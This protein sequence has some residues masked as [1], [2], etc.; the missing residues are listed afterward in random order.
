MT[1][2]ASRDRTDRDDTAEDA[3]SSE[4]RR[5]E[6]GIA[7]TRANMTTTIAAL[8]AKLNPTE[9]RAKVG[10]ELEH[11]EQRVKALVKEELQEAKT[12]VKEELEVA[13]QLL[14]GEMNEA[15]GK[16]KRGLVEAKE[17]VKTE[18][19]D[20]YEG[21]KQNVRNATLGKV[22]DL[23]TDLGDKMNDTKDTLIDTIR[24]N[25]L[26][27][28]VMGAG[29]VWLLMSRSRDASER[30]RGTGRAARGPARSEA[31]G[32]FGYDGSHGMD[33]EGAG[34]GLAEAAS[35]GLH[36]VTGGVAH[37]AKD[38]GDMAGRVAEGTSDAASSLVHRAGDAASAVAHSASGMASS[39]AHGAS[40]AAAGIAHG[41]SGAASSIAQGA[42]GAASFVAHTAEDAA[43]ALAE[44]ARKGVRGVGRGYET[45]L[46][47]NPLV[48]GGLALGIGAV[49]GLALP[50]TTGEDKVLGPTRDRV[51]K[52]ATEVAHDAAESV[53]HLAEKSTDSAKKA[54]EPGARS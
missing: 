54:L 9:L 38:A 37:A 5:L 34:G 52:R 53:V 23:A 46:R 18:L 51:L 2:T 17:S 22:E 20:A 47:D 40:D 32:Q 44:G 42:T 21:A 30:R 1:N 10:V 8:E 3:G 50:R 33:P 7:E 31:F 41:A 48:L 19:K 45:A 24:N 35:S 12:L 39:W 11:V 25:P 28:A 26:P 16:I 36:K 29:L 14:R 49:V 4:T 27:A 15:E 6:S 43:G 13:Q